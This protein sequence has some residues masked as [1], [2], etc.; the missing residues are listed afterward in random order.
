[1]SNILVSFW[2]VV[3]FFLGI[4]GTRNNFLSPIF[5]LESAAAEWECPVLLASLIHSWRESRRRDRHPW[6]LTSRTDWGD[7]PPRK[8]KK[9]KYTTSRRSP[10]FKQERIAVAKQ[11]IL[12]TQKKAKK[13]LWE[14]PWRIQH[15]RTV[16]SQSEACTHST[17]RFRYSCPTVVVLSIHFW[18][19]PDNVNLTYRGS[20][21]TVAIVN[22][23]RRNI[24]VVLP[25]FFSSPSY[26]LQKLK[27]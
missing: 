8:R 1:M 5:G 21:V 7:R 24:Q 16:S 26:F 10:H 6:W 9:K 18:G 12:W 25:D 19:A 13:W 27:R 22:M 15:I 11:K 17:C 23:Q 14:R 4:H 3:S 2:V 20:R